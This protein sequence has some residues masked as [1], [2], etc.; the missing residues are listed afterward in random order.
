MRLAVMYIWVSRDVGHMIDSG[1]R[2]VSTVSDLVIL[3]LSVPRKTKPQSA[4]TALVIRLN[5]RRMEEVQTYRY[6][7]VDMSSDGGMGEEVNH[8]IIEAKKVWGE[9]KDVWKKRHI[10][11]ET[12]VG[13]Y[14]GIFEPSLLYGCEV[15]SLKVRERKRM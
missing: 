1:S 9:L 8:R 12:K 13:M 7:G 2:S 14:E 6:L 3:P 10:F 4:S 11:R 5:D 15:W